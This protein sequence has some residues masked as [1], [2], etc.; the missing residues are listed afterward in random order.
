MLPRP[1]ARPQPLLAA[2]V[3]TEAEAALADIGIRLRAVKTQAWSAEAA[4][5]SGLE[6][7]WRP[8]GLT[9]VGVPLG[10]PLPAG[11]LPAEDDL[12]R[13]ELGSNSYEANCC[14][15]VV[16]RAKV[17]LAKVARGQC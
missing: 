11:G 15:E 7:Q 12:R 17:L 4:C 6:E 10:E 9:V 3:L 16:E 13:L 14:F 8:D 5:P 2:R 1:P